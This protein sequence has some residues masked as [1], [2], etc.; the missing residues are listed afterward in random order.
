M[1]VIGMVKAGNDLAITIQL[2]F[3]GAT[4]DITSATCTATIRD[5]EHPSTVLISAHA[6]TVTTAATSVV[7]LTLTDTEE[8]AIR[9]NPDYVTAI[10][11]LC[12][13]KVVESGGA[14]TNSDVIYL[15]FVRPVT[16]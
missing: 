3:G 16:A 14:V 11:H 5:G 8:A 13:V 6:V 4:K 12:D 1:P 10:N 7:T 9:T 2:T 15:P